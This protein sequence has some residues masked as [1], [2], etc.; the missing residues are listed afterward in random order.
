M[1]KPGL[2]DRGGQS[3]RRTLPRLAG[4]SGERFRRFLTGHCLEMKT[5][6]MEESLLLSDLGCVLFSIS[7]Q[8]E[9]EKQTIADELEHE[10]GK[11]RRQ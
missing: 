9:Q 4:C 10:N 8:A 6:L 7:C 11:G 5:D 1:K 3:P 2:V